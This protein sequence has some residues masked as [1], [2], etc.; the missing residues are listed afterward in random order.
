VDGRL[1]CGHV[2]LLDQTTAR[3]Q[4]RLRPPQSGS[5]SCSPSAPCRTA[6]RATRTL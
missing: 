2:P 5:G 4:R 6:P 3:L 1:Q